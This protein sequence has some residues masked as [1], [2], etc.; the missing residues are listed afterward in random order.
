MEL[1][2]QVQEDPFGLPYK[3][4]TKKIGDPPITERMEPEAVRETID[5]L[6]PQHPALTD[7]PLEVEGVIPPL[8]EAEVDA[9]VERI[10]SK[11]KK[12]PGPD[13]IL[14]SVWTIVHRAL[15]GILAAVFNVCLRSGT[16]PTQWKVAQQVLVLEKLSL[17]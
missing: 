4:V 3:I 14:N 11:A 17:L 6:F 8:S 5:H 16:F 9:A 7:P 10:R 13:G 2:S 12:A 15:P 1:C